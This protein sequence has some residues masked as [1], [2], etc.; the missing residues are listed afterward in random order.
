MCLTVGLPLTTIHHPSWAE[1]LLN[2]SPMD[3]DAQG[4][5]EVGIL[6]GPEH[7]GSNRTHDMQLGK[8]PF[9]R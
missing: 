4:L 7:C 9:Y 1:F 5:S 8:L 3:Q 6:R 2:E